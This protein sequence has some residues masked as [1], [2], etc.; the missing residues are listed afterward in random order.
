MSAWFKFAVLLRSDLR[1]QKRSTLL[2][3]VLLRSILSCDMQRR[4]LVSVV[5]SEKQARENSN[6]AYDTRK[7]GT[8]DVDPKTGET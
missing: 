2:A 8:S 7:P 6:A 1:F 3:T 5:V 4:F